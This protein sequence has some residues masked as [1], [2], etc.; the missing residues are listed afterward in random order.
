MAEIAGR[1]GFRSAAHFTCT[2]RHHTDQ[3]PRVP[4]AIKA[5]P[6]T[7]LSQRR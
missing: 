1:W 5:R 4:P 2:V 3:L 6:A 7:D